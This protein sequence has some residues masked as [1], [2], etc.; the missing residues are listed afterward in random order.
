M[1]NIQFVTAIHGNESLPVLALTSLGID[2]IVANPKALACGERFVER[3]MNTSFGTSGNTYEEKRAEKVINLLSKKKIVIDLHTFSAESKPFVIIVDKKMFDFA[4]SL[5][6]KHI[7]Y[8]RHNIKSG[9]ALINHRRG[10]SIEIGNHHKPESFG[11]VIELITR[12]SGKDKKTKGVK[13]Y[14]VYDIIKKPGRYENFKIHKN[15][16]IPVLAGE[17]A[18]SFYGLKAKVI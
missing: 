8:M 9:N 7:V 10:V 6:F 1:K 13:F 11:R 5:G 2:Q 3:D 17:N 18:Y 16:F 14:E 4:T 15:G 12:L